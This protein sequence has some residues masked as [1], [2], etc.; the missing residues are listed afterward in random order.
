[1]YFSM[2]WLNTSAVMSPEPSPVNLH[3][4]YSLK[5][6]HVIRNSIYTQLWP[7]NWWGREITIENLRICNASDFEIFYTLPTH[8]CWCG[9]PVNDSYQQGQFFRASLASES[10]WLQPVLVSRDP[11]Q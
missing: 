7:P 1:M 3:P 10:H 2:N 8:T 4:S 5:V 9:P 6:V 11:H